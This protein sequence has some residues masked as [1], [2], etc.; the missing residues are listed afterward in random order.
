MYILPSFSLLERLKCCMKPY[1]IYGI[2]VLLLSIY[3]QLHNTL[4]SIKGIY[5]LKNK[6]YKNDFCCI[7]PSY[8]YSFIIIPLRST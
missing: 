5:R 3:I 8:S 1:Y 7:K 4:K 2:Q 6:I